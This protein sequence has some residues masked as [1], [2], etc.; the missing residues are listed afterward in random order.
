MV[1]RLLAAIAA[2]RLLWRV[3][4]LDLNEED[5]REQGMR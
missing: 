3:P 4:A 5:G 1:T 2:L